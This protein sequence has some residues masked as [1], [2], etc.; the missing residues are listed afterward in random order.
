MKSAVNSRQS[1]VASAD[2]GNRALEANSHPLFLSLRFS[3]SLFP[4]FIFYL[5]LYVLFPLAV[6]FLGGCGHKTVVR[7]PELVA[8][9]PVNDLTLEVVSKG[10]NLRWGRAQKT[11]GGRDL[12]DLAGFVV[13][14]AAQDPQGQSS[15][16]TQIAMIPVEDRDRFRKN[17]RFSYTDENLEA[18]TLYRYR[19]LA[20][21]LDDYYGKASNTVELVWK[22][23]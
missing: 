2:V 15:A 8:P 18:G 5:P 3:V 21:T 19:V 4:R 13:L 20:F 7:P 16:F 1:T 23:E 11:A 17:K 12:E 6:S 22:E 14:R 10:I 9:M